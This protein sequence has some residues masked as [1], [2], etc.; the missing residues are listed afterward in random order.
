M[1]LPG[2]PPSPPPALAQLYWS[3]SRALGCPPWLQS[4]AHWHPKKGVRE[5]RFCCRSEVAAPCSSVRLIL[6]LSRWKLYLP[7]S[8]QD[9]MAIR[10][11]YFLELDLVPTCLSC[12]SF[13]TLL[14]LPHCLLTPTMCTP[15]L[16]L[17]PGDAPALACC[18]CHYTLVLQ[19][20]DMCP[21]F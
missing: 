2:G 15:P 7:R 19:S 13:L 21:V 14:P 18:S 6:C 1:N 17:L 11:S 3:S 12:I 8:F 10:F 4:L 16:P 9:P 20:R 5:W